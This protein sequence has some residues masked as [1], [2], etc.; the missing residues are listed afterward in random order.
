MNNGNEVENNRK[1]NCVM[2]RKALS[3]GDDGPV[4]ESWLG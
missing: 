3:A 2:L 1:I 4:V